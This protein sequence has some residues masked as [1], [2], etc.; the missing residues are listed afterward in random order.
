MRT[1][2]TYRYRDGNLVAVE[3]DRGADGDVDRVIAL[4][5]GDRG[6]LSSTVLRERGKVVSSTTYA[7]ERGPCD[8]RNLLPE[9]RA[10]CLEG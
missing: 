9:M 1:V 8:T 10:M 7:Y 2:R 6:R 3:I 5:Y 4:R